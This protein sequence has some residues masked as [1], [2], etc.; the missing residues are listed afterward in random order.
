MIPLRSWPRRCRVGAWKQVGEDRAGCAGRTGEDP[1]GTRL[2]G[3]IHR[4]AGDCLA[5]VDGG[6]PGDLALEGS[7]VRILAEFDAPDWSPDQA[8]E[9]VSGQITQFSG[10][11]DA[12][13]AAND[14][15]ASGAISALRAAGIS[16]VPP[17]SGQDIDLVAV[18]RIVTGDQYMT[19]FKAFSQQART[20]AELAVRLLDGQS[21]AT[22]AR[23]NGVPSILLAP[24]AVTQSTIQSAL[25]FGGVFTIAEICAEPY[26]KA[27]IGAGLGEVV[28]E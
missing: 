5:A 26:A 28:E 13:Y 24:I 22:T 12:V 1:G 11:I 9:W 6:G 25:V 16:P 20:A 23:V 15:T 4:V 8:Q 27:C 17:V 10:Q 21:S 14:G 19:V 3:E 7:D 2:G 18:Q